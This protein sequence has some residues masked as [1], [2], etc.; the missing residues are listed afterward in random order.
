MHIGKT[1]ED[2]LN[3][4]CEHGVLTVCWD[5]DKH[6]VTIEKNNIC[7]YCGSDNTMRFYDIDTIW[8]FLKEI[9]K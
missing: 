3:D 8:K 2:K 1:L 5:C 7:A 4:N 9:T 6:I